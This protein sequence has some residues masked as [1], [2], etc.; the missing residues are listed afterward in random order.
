MATKISSL[1]KIALTDILVHS[2][3]TLSE[4]FD[5]SIFT[6]FFCCL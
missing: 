3:I 6:D 4:M 2:K 1:V 5:K